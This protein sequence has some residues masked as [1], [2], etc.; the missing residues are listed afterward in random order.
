MKSD[1]GII[2]LGIMGSAIS[3][4]LI[5]EGYPVYGFDIDPGR[6]EALTRRGG[7]ALA[8]AREVA[9][10]AAIVVTSLPD[11]AALQDV[12]KGDDG[13]VAAGRP[14]LL[15][16]ETSTLPLDVKCDARATLQQ[17]G[18]TALDC[19]L[20]GTGAQARVRDLAVYASGDAAAV[21]R[22]R[23]VFEAFAR[24]VHYLGDFGNGTRMKLVANLLVAIHNVSA[25][26]AFVLGMKA[27]LDATKIYEVIKDG[28]GSSRMFEVR[29]PMM[30]DG[31][32][33]D[34]TMRVDMWQ[35]DMQIIADF[36]RELG[37]PAPLLSAAAPIYTEA[38]A[39]GRG[40]Q[41]TAAVCAVLERLAGFSRE[42]AN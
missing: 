10:R 26:E 8:S 32:Y 3:A 19:P 41:D 17:A 36:A 1:V 30:V 28:A 23:P 20:S 22:C 39:E 35:K 37:C 9:T 27:G 7:T 5:D 15:L 14:G 40:R 29:G 12:C 16:I 2:G 33:D 21:A 25:A 42:P 6:N 18:V 11:V 34:A 38:Q 4:S 24:S 13:V 31:R